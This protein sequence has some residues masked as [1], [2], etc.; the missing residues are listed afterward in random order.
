MLLWIVLAAKPASAIIVADY[1]AATNPPSG[2]W[3]V[4]WD[5]VYKYKN[6]SA[7]AVGPN[8]LLTAAHVADDN[9]SSNITVNGTVYYQ[10]EVIFHSAAHD[11]EHTAKADLA[12]VR[13]DKVFPGWYPLYAGGFPT[14]PSS[15]KLSAVLIGYGRTGTV[16]S[17]YY[18]EHAGGNGIRRWGTQKID[19]TE[20]VN[21]DVGGPTGMTYNDGIKMMFSLGDTTYE[22]GVG[23]YDSGGGTFV[24]DGGTWKLAGINTVR[25]GSAPNYTG[26]FA[27]SVPAYAAW[28]A[29]VMNPEG[30]LD[31]DG[32][33]NGWERQY[34]STTGLTASADNDGDGFNN[35]EEYIAD[36]HPLDAGSFLTFRGEVR[37][38]V[39][40]F[41]FNGSTGRLYQVVCAVNGLDAVP[42]TWTVAH[43][44]PVQGAGTNSV[45]TVTNTESAVFYRLQVSLP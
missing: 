31:G 36:T 44:G 34:G 17:T 16:Y 4:T 42:L 13:F 32:I 25:Y 7:V 2:S 29:A 1:A 28:A 23:V 8:W 6:C 22:A 21:Y 41:H 33:P 39:Q 27:V 38:E 5:F 11:P 43:P 26:T 3:N 12:L 9:A 19:G 15:K 10:R 40:M 45:I 37:P 24:N 30:D 18:T 35:M 14:V 20:T